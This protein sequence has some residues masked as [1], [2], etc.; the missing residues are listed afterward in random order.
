MKKIVLLIVLTLFFSLGGCTTFTTSS[1]PIEV[2]YQT[3]GGMTKDFSGYLAF[4]ISDPT[5]DVENPVHIVFEYGHDYTLEL[6]PDTSLIHTMAVYV[7]SSTVNHNRDDEDYILFYENKMNNFM[8]EEYRCTVDH[9]DIF[10][11]II[12]QKSFFLDISP[13]NVPYEKGMLYF[14]LYQGD[15]VA[16]TEMNLPRVYQVIYFTNVDGEL[17]FTKSNPYN[18]A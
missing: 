7:S 18:E 4:S 8:T 11:N 12:F 16:G 14:V 9:S 6:Q 10:A 3:G 2:G 1:G 5:G 13:S 15:F 17:T